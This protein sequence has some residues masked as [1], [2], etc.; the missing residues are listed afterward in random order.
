MYTVGADLP[1]IATAATMQK[2]VNRQQNRSPCCTSFADMRISLVHCLLVPDDRCRPCTQ[3]EEH[4]RQHEAHMK[5]ELQK[6]VQQQHEQ[7]QHEQQKREQQLREEQQQKEL[8]QRAQQRKEQEVCYS[9]L[10][11]S[12]VCCFSLHFLLVNHM[13][14]IF[15]QAESTLPK[16]P[17]TCCSSAR[18]RTEGLSYMAAR[19]IQCCCAGC[20][21]AAAAASASISAC[22]SACESACKSVCPA[23]AEWC[24]LSCY[25]ELAQR[26]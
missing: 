9:N 4:R 5:R 10:S 6:R 8:Q 2:R 23:A 21:T 15:R 22:K 24:P 17:A 16:T 7:Q 25:R 11:I 13:H 20:S 14:I 1:S 18:C 12:Q 19:Q 26:C 3:A